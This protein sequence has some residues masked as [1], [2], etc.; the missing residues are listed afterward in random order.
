MAPT[1]AMVLL[2]AAA[3]SSGG[4]TFVADDDLI[5][6]RSIVVN[7]TGLVDMSLSDHRALGDR[8]CQ[9]G[10]ALPGEY[11]VVVEEFDLDRYGTSGVPDMVVWQ[12]GQRVCPDRMQ[13]EPPSGGFSASGPA[14]RVRS[15]TPPPEYPPALP[16]DMLVDGLG[17]AFPGRW[18]LSGSRLEPAEV[19]VGQLETVL[20]DAGWRTE[21]IGPLDI[22]EARLW[23]VDLTQD[24]FDGVL[25]VLDSP[26]S[27]TS[28]VF[29][30]VVE[31]SAQAS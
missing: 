16:A 18:V 6:V 19:V 24:G 4:S 5:D 7:Q 23:S 2:M 10:P 25:E 17:Y 26:Q 8:V 15:D 11:E 22:D 3:C 21:T 29:L 9:L 14:E 20:A 30:V 28:R 27:P 1:A 12:V 31:S 13:H